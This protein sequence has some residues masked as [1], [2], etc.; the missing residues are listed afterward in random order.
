LIR[1]EV[2]PDTMGA[3]SAVQ[4]RFELRT[5]IGR[6]GM[7]EVWRARD[8]L[9]GADVAVK[10]LL[11]SAE[12]ARFAREAELLATVEHPGIVRYIAHAAGFLAMEW[13]EGIDLAA[14]L[15]RGPLPWTDAEAL[16]QCIAGALAHAHA[17]GI[18][19]RD[20]KPSNIFLVDADAAR[21]KVLDF[22]IALDPRSRLTRDGTIV[23]TPGFMAPEQVRGSRV[24]PEADVFSLGCVLF[25]CVTGRA[26]FDGA[27]PLAVLSKV[28]LEEPPRLS[29]V[30]DAPPR[31]AA[32]VDRMLAKEPAQRPT[33]E[34]V[35]YTVQ[36]G[37]ASTSTRSG[38]VALGA[39]E[40]SLVSVIVVGSLDIQS[41]ATLAAEAERTTSDVVAS[42]VRAAGARLEPVL[43]GALA[44]LVSGTG[45]AR[46]QVVRAARCALVL[47]TVYPDAP[48]VLVTGRGLAG[49]RLPVGEAID[50]AVATMARTGP[51]DGVRIDA[52]TAGLLAD[53]F[54]IEEECLRG[55][56]EGASGGTVLGKR[57]RFVG[58]DRDVVALDVEAESF[59][60]TRRGRAVVVA[61]PAGVGKSRLVNEWLAAFRGRH[62]T[63]AVWSGAA[64]PMSAGSA[65]HLL[66]QTLRR[67][68]GIRSGKPDDAQTA[69]QRLARFAAGTSEG[70]L[71]FLGE[72]LGLPRVQSEAMK[73]AQSDGSLMA[74][75]LKRAFSDLVRV[76]TA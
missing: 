26:A 17:R 13:L 11:G 4:D 18:V 44:V 60:Q 59:L 19:H 7:G 74:T 73:A 23:G 48:I 68:C 45:E 35:A 66:R 63:A 16:A 29:A 2:L 32:L 30:S 52:L 61:G 9:T 43:G 50:R 12:R 40:L 58:R 36:L 28:L 38:P 71:A 21:P 47:R 14:R 5:C 70:S 10:I 56:R 49:E 20:L 76:H 33:A 34:E 72:I 25:E 69:W 8:R 65:L 22:G 54:I 53:R 39:R 15:A 31:I 75:N 51:R 1:G 3:V 41:A 46:D 67:A 27:T 57:T 55:A 6:G 62:P 37:D 24:G 64:D 42:V